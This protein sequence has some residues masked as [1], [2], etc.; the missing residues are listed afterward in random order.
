M[1]EITVPAQEYYDEVNNQIIT[2]NEQKL[3]LEHSLISLS[4]WESKWHKVFLKDEARP[5]NEQLDYIR[6]MTINKVADPLVYYGLTNK[7][8]AEIDA[9][10][11]DP[12]T[13]TTFNELHRTY[14]KKIITNEVI[15]SWM[16]D[17][18]I[19]IEC[20]KWHLNRL[21]TLIRVCNDNYA[22]KKKMSKK[23]TYN[24][25]DEINARNRKRFGTKG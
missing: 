16:F 7:Q 14:R 15:Y 25:Y 24:R 8:L 20:E 12:M 10:I 6:C 18:G 13:A 22:P 19:P 17:L 21:L 11:V 4:K 2:V 5:V 9:Y 3:V 1:L 23:D